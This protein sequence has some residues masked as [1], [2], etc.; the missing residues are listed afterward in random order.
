VRRTSNSSRCSPLLKP[1][2]LERRHRR[3]RRDRRERINS[4]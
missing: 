4:L 1:V 2:S 3:K